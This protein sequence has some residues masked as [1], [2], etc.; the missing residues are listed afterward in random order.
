MTARDRDS[1]R[2]ARA[3]L[4]AFEAADLPALEDALERSAGLLPPISPYPD[5]EAERWELVQALSQNL[6][7]GIRRVRRGLATHIEGLETSLA[8]L[9][10]LARTPPVMMPV[11]IR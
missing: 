2:A 10:H 3:I 4:S 8:L 9:A 1:A 11:R 7:E 6:L 5:L